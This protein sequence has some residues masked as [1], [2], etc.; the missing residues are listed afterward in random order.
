MVYPANNTTYCFV[1]RVLCMWRVWILFTS[2][3]LSFSVTLFVWSV[4]K[5]CVRESDWISS[6]VNTTVAVIAI[7]LLTDEFRLHLYA[8]YEVCV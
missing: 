2:P 6:L 5:S 8:L 4:V 3:L 7:V 1:A